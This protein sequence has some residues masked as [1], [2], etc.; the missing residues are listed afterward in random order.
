MIKPQTILEFEGLI[1]AGCLLAKPAGIVCHDAEHRAST[2][3]Q[4]ICCLGT[5]DVKVHAP[6]LLSSSSCI[7]S[8][9]P[10]RFLPYTPLLKNDRIFRG[11]SDWRIGSS[12]PALIPDVRKYFAI[13]LISCIPCHVLCSLWM[14][15]RQVFQ[16]SQ[17]AKPIQSNRYAKILMNEN[18]PHPGYF[19]PSNMRIFLPC[20]L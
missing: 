8:V 18:I 2:V 11:N 10:R 13:F 15:L 1:Y 7:E 16:R 20:L 5:Q 14:L 12:T 6:L 17:H 19:S 3:K 9:L 4:L